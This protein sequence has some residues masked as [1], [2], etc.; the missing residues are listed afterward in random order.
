[1]K[2]I[3]SI[4]I[5]QFRTGEIWERFWSPGSF[6]K[7]TT[8]AEGKKAGSKI[9]LTREDIPAIT[10]ASAITVVV[11]VLLS[12][13]F[14]GNSRALAFFIFIVVGRIIIYFMNKRFKKKI[15]EKI[16]E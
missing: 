12:N 6:Q 13:I 7:D 3:I 9:I 1:M 14:E 5:D 8:S 2:S 11:I 4:F 15:A 10:V 16:R